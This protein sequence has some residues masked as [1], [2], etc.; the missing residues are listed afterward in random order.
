MSHEQPD[1][2]LVQVPKR[3]KKF[4]FD[5]NS[6]AALEVKGSLRTVKDLLDKELSPHFKARYKPRFSA[7]STVMQK[8]INLVLEATHACNL[9]CKYCFV[10]LYYPD[11]VNH[12]DCATMDFETAKRAI[13]RYLD[14]DQ[15]GAGVG[16]FGG[17]PMLNWS[18]I[19][20]V[21]QYVI[22]K[23][24][25]GGKVCRSCGGSG[26][27]QGAECERCRGLGKMKPGL[28]ITTNGTLFTSERV[29]FL[30]KHG[31]SLIVSIDGD[32]KCHN[33]YR[34]YRD[35]RPSFSKVMEGLKLLRGKRIAQSTTLRSTFTADT[36]SPIAE[37]LEFLNQLCDD[38]LASWVSVEPASLLEDSTGKDTHQE[39]NIH[40]VW[41]IFE[42]QYLDAADWWVKRAREEKKPRFHNVHKLL[43]RILWCIHSGSECG[44]GRGYLSVNGKGEIFACHRESNT[45]I[46][47]LD[48]GIDEFLRSQWLE[49]RIYLRKHCMVCPI[50]YICGGGCREDSLGDTKDI[51]TPSP[52]DCMLK[53]LWF[54]SSLY[55]LSELPKEVVVKYC[56]D[57]ATGSHKG[58]PCICTPISPEQVKKDEFGHFLPDHLIYNVPSM[59]LVKEK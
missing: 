51:R 36:S 58:S 55:I 5:G 25:E 32:E 22:Q 6:L 2:V 52:L 10:S 35:G 57:P 53:Q 15:P 46:G 49:N 20:K 9:A 11:Q 39:I 44:A 34:P 8:A 13:D 17:E 47:H 3:N 7:S 54:V 24:K 28:H 33:A 19:E 31:Y 18:L 23:V 48:Y 12:Q 16:F 41:S 30:E 45:Y 37:R 38:N 50:R 42:D 40:N 14:L 26:R 56:I 1:V 59:C 27:I 29:E 4:L 43:E 21:T